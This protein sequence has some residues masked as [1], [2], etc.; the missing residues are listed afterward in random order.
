MSFK[1]PMACMTFCRM[2]VS[3]MLLY[4]IYWCVIHSYTQFIKLLVADSGSS[5]LFSSLASLLERFS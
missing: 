1:C 5:R 4:V 3:G 2:S